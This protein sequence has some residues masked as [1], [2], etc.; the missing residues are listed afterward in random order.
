MGWGESSSSRFSLPFFAETCKKNDFQMR[1]LKGG[2]CIF[3]IEV[4]LT[5]ARGRTSNKSFIKQLTYN[6]RHRI[7]HNNQFNDINVMIILYYLH[8]TITFNY[9]SPSSNMIFLRLYL[10]SKNIT[11]CKNKSYFKQ[12]FILLPLFLE[13]MNL[14]WLLSFNWICL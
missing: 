14:P 7:N 5:P 8:S 1:E 12:I 4:F 13:W 10:S 9:C 2:W 6:Q 11:G 3:F